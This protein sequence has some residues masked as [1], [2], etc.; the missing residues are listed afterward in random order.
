VSSFAAAEGVC[1]EEKIRSS[2][3]SDMF[4]GVGMEKRMSEK[5]E[6]VYMTVNGWL[7][8][9]LCS[10]VLCSDVREGRG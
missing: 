3:K 6:Q 9:Y 8:R 1:R 10:L 4:R 2:Q 5:I 7:P